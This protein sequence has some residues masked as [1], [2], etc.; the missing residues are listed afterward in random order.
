MKRV[1]FLLLIISL[2]AF[3]QIYSSPIRSQKTESTIVYNKPV[4]LSKSA[5]AQL[6]C[7][8]WLRTQAIGQ[9]VTVEDLDTSRNQITVEANFN[10]TSFPLS[11]LNAGASI[12]NINPNYTFQAGPRESASNIG[13]IINDYTP[14]LSLLPCENKISVEDA[15]AFNIGDTVLMIQMKG[16]IID[17]TNTAGFG[18]ITDYRNAGNYEIN[19]V[20]SKAGNI[21]ELKNTLTRRYDLPDGKVQLVRIPYYTT[22]NITS[23]LTCL[24]WDGNKGGVLVLNARD[25]IYLNA[26]ID[27]TG[28]GFN[29]GNDPATNPPVFNCYE[30]EFFY[31]VN[32]DLASEKGEG[33][34]LISS[35]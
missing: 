9:S 17:S 34:A 4:P 2:T 5:S 24:P 3:V 12:N 32:P 29:G 22:A 26:N 31:S 35:S 16:A 25:T 18:T 33:I 10:G 19:Y 23:T 7:N 1:L 14:V 20:K 15:S 11:G 13:N 30:N 27:V 28:K 8:N 21:I 6:T